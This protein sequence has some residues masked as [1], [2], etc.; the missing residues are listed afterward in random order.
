M[1][2]EL[3]DVVALD[4]PHMHHSIF[5]AGDDEL[6]VRGEVALDDRGFVEEVGELEELVALEGVQ[7]DDAVVGRGQHQVLSV[8]TKPHYLYLIVVLPPLSEWSGLA[9]LDSIEADPHDLFVLLLLRP[10]NSKGHPSGIEAGNREGGHALSF[11]AEFELAL[12]MT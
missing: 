4:V 3:G 9:A 1:R 7:E 12:C 10:S 6:G 8:R 5:A 11:H 2:G